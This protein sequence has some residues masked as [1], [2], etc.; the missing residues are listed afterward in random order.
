MKVCTG[1]EHFQ[2]FAS[3]SGSWPKKSYICCGSREEAPVYL[4][5]EDVW[6]W[7]SKIQGDSEEREAQG[8]HPPEGGSSLSTQTQNCQPRSILRLPTG[9]EQSGCRDQSILLA[10]KVEV[11]EVQNILQD[12]K[13]RRQAAHPALNKGNVGMRLLLRKRFLMKDSGPQRCASRV[14]ETS[15]ATE[16][17][18]RGHPIPVPLVHL[19]WNAQ[20]LWKGMQMGQLIYCWRACPTRSLALSHGSC[21]VSIASLATGAK[22]ELETSKDGESNKLPVGVGRESSDPFPSVHLESLQP[23]LT[24]AGSLKVK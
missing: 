7:V 2:F 18:G 15:K 5:A 20:Y 24:V 16:N 10:K 1:R 9:K 19:H 17:E 23:I 3:Q 4:Q 6:E 21:A 8:W 22:S 14:W 12:E 11:V 13:Q